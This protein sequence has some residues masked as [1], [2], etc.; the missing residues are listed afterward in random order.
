[1]CQH[2]DIAIIGSGF[3]GSIMAMI[4]RRLGRS[5]VVLER[6]RH[7]RFAIGESSTPLANLLLDQIATRYNLPSLRDLS[8]WGVWQRSHPE[9][10]CGLKR[11]F[12]FYHHTLEQPFSDNS[13]RKRQLLVAASPRDEIADTHWYRQDFDQ[14]LARESVALGAVL[15]EDSVLTNIN[16]SREGAVLDGTRNGSP[17][18]LQANLVIDAGGPRGFLHRT[19]NLGELEPIHLPATQALYAHFSGA[20]R[21]DALYPETQSPPFPVDDAAVHHVFNGGWIWVLRFNNGITSAGASLET[22][23]AEELRLS[24]GAPAWERLLK[25]LPSVH[26]IFEN[27]SPTSPFVYTPRLSFLTERIAGSGWVMLPSAAGFIDPLLSTG[28]P[29]TLLGIARLGRI[30]ENGNAFENFEQGLASYASQTHRDLRTV[31]G[32]IAA[33]YATMNDPELFFEL[34]KI[35]FAAVSFTE[36]ARRLDKP[37]IAGESFLLADHPAF[38][39]QARQ[40]VDLALRRPTGNQ[41]NNLLRQ[42][43]NTIAPVDVAGLSDLSRRGWYPA[44]AEDLL[45]AAHKLD[46]NRAAI[47]EMLVRTGFFNDHEILGR[48]ESD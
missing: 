16:I 17:L 1:M 19:L 29:L 5:V 13:T 10:A 25:K 36:S 18:Q 42:I 7:P 37:G 41:R 33:L 46:T 28:I 12:T 32:F 30:I 4:A 39:P 23:L 21:W 43:S 35:Y 34:T 40:C 47:N 2:F 6:Q 3:A 27:A 9:I 31:E 45:N 20:R 14:F 11:G 22:P 38:G 15:L 24:E 8:K 44:K 26:A 48:S